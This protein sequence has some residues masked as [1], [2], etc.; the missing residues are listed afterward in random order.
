VSARRALVTGITGQDGSYLAELL[1]GQGHEV[2]GLVRPPLDRP[3]PNVDGLR[4]HVRLV[5]ADLADSA[6]LAGAVGEAA[7]DDVFHLAA[8]TFVPASW[9]DARATLAEIPGATATVLD[10]AG[11][12]GARILVAASPEV[13]GDAR[14]VSPQ[15]EDAP[16]RPRSPYGVA[17]LAAHELVRVMRD[18]RG[19]HAC[20]AIT[21]NHESPRR[22]HR[23]VTRKITRAAAAIKLGM[24]D[25]VLLGDLEAR[26]DWS[27]ARDVVRGMALALA[28][29]EPGDYV[30][31]SG[32]ARTVG[33]FAAAAFAAVGL[34]AADHVRVD[35]ALVRA[36]E[37]TVLVGDPARA[38]AVLGWR[39]EIG[40]EALVAEMVDADLAALRPQK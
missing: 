24:E 25:H 14:G 4:E 7:P 27:H 23:F 36:P 15:D 20:S 34:D 16:R 26:R 17:K 22:P 10:A 30:L 6:A 12:L 19:I 13:F 29:D 40:F 9:D 8:P 38:R 1:L 39:P 31:A 37:P 35:P 21:Y 18:G 32:T 2:V 11:A 28:H 3:L 5:A 33:D